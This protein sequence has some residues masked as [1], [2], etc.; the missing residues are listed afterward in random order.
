MSEYEIRRLQDLRQT[1]LLLGDEY[2]ELLAAP[3][4]EPELEVERKYSLF[5]SE[6]DLLIRR[7]PTKDEESHT[8]HKPKDDL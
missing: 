6:I 1:V 4:G 2:P 3:Y 8:P 7:T 5:L